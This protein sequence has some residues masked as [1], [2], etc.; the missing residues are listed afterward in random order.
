M[1][2]DAPAYHRNKQPML[3]VLQSAL[4]KTPLKIIEIASGSGQHGP[5]F[6]SQINNLT[7]WPT[8]ISNAALTSINAWQQHISATAIQPATFLDVTEEQWI[9]GQPIDGLPNQA[10]A[11]LSMNMIHIAPYAAT[12][13]LLAGAS[14]RLSANGLLILYGP[15]KQHGVTFAPSNQSFDISLKSRNPQWGIRQLEDVEA[16]AN[17]HNLFLKQIFNLPA[18]NL[19]VVFEKT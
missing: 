13:G 14:K 3:D 11:I 18:N 2:Q 8:D 10:D 7:W 5:F 6:T 4:P 19:A 15:F 9:L 1:R 16:I 17:I 12:K